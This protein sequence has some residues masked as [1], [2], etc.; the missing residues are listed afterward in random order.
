MGPIQIFLFGFEDFAATGA[1]AAELGALSDAGI[2]RI[3]DARFM[4]K[5]TEDD[6]V[7]ARVTDLDEFER[8]DLRAAA[9]ALIGLG[10]G[11]VL[12]GEEGAEAG[13][14]LGA[15]AAMAGG[16]LGLSADDVAALGSEMELGDALLLL[17]LE[18]VWAVRLRD[19]LQIS[20]LTYADQNYLTPEG[21][22]ALGAMLGIETAIAE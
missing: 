14:L 16:E 18:Q 1:I 20:G 4:L 17:V 3:I 7:V 8:E 11:A 13:F 5:D 12:G 21:L 6:I 9:G 15:E 22:V 19:A 10:A 2:V